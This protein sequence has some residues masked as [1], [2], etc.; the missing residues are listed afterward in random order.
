MKSAFLNQVFYA[1]RD[2]RDFTMPVSPQGQTWLISVPACVDAFMHAAT[3]DTKA[4]GPRRAFTL[5]AQRVR[6]DMLIAALKQ[7]FRESNSNITYAPDA[8]LEAQFAGYPPL[9]TM[10]ADAL[11]FRH[12]GDMATLVARAMEGS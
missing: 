6:I 10:Q 7:R 8:A 11:G 1:V 2:G 3:V 9:T 5:P 4:L 12:D